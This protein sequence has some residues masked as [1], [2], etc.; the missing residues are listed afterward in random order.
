MVAQLEAYLS[1]RD[2]QPVTLSNVHRLDKETSGVLLLSKLPAATRA[3]GKEFKARRVA[4]T[5]WAALYGAVV[6]RR[7]VPPPL[8]PWTM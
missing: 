1:A 8:P 7:R 2:A 5:Y 6:R 4:K 3:L